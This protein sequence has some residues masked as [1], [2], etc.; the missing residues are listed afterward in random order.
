M[1]RIPLHSRTIPRAIASWAI[2]IYRRESPTKDRQIAKTYA[3]ILIRQN[4]IDE[5]AK[6]S[7][8]MLKSSPSDYDTQVLQGQIL[9]RQ[10]K[11]ND[12]ISVLETAVK[13]SPDNPMG[14]YYLG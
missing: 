4:R 3:E 7:D 10:G 14:H 12:A 1:P 2:S 8:A 5:A 11:P 13:S 6:I 9:A